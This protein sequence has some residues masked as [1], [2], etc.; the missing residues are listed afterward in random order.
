MVWTREVGFEAESWK[1]GTSSAGALTYAASSSRRNRRLTHDAQPPV[2]NDE[3][4][5]LLHVGAAS[6]TLKHGLARD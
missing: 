6:F 2:A 3:H 4:R 5:H 1:G